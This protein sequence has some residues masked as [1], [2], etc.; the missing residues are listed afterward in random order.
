MIRTAT[1]PAHS[2]RAN[3]ATPDRTASFSTAPATPAANAWPRSI[4]DVVAACVQAQHLIYRW[5]GVRIAQVLEVSEL[6][7]R[8]AE[9]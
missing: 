4:P 6:K 3:C 9:P 5:D 1:W 2:W 8:S 7:R